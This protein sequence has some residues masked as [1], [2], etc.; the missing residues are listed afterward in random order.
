M[1]I[2]LGAA[3]GL[4]AWFLPQAAVAQGGGTVELGALGQYTIFDQSLTLD[5]AI[6]AGWN[7]IFVGPVPGMSDVLAA[8]GR[9]WP[10]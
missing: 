8:A 7:D 3:L 4:A 10:R 5:D 9:R 2:L 1:K 6:L